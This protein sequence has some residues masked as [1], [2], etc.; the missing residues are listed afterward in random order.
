MIVVEPTTTSVSLCLSYQQSSICQHV[1]CSWVLGSNG[2]IG[3][4]A[5]YPAGKRGYFPKAGFEYA[6]ECW[7]GTMATEGLHLL[8]ERDVV[9]EEV[10]HLHKVPSSNPLHKLWWERF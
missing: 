6:W 2:Y 4:E 9:S 5:K 3:Q 7:K 8:N 10:M 1:S